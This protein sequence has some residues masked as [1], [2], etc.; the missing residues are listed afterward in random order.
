MTNKPRQTRVEV[1]SRLKKQGGRA[2][3]AELMEKSPLVTVV[4]APPCHGI[5]YAKGPIG[6]CI[7]DFED[8]K[9]PKLG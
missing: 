9:P 7:G 2:F 1:I 6:P 3:L 5:I 4:P 8:E